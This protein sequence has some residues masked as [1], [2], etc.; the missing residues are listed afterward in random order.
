MTTE[1]QI[2]FVSQATALLSMR[3]SDFDAY[4]AYGEV[5]DQVLV[6]QKGNNEF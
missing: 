6:E 1:E 4:S 5:I 2:R 3:D